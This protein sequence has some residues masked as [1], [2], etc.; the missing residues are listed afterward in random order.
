MTT[1][2]LLPGMDGTGELFDPFLQALPADLAPRVVRYPAEPPLSYPQLESFVCSEIPEAEPFV[3]LAESFSGPIAV[4]IA[5]TAPNRLAG[6]I[7]CC[8][9]VSNPHRWLS[10]FF[11]LGG[12]LPTSLVPQVLISRLLLGRWQTKPLQRALRHSLLQVP[13]ATL[14]A[15]LRAIRSVNVSDQLRSVAVP[16]LSLRATNDLLVPAQASDLLTALNAR[17]QSVE[18]AAP[19]LLLQAVPDQAARIVVDFVRSLPLTA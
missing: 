14:R 18:L 6:L 8:T 19:H 15:R 16:I 12:V 7:L 9:F 3:L 13:L 10:P 1:L 4:S 5:A 11:G 17:T 2:L